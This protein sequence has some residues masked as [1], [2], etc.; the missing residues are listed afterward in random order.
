MN[1][2]RRIKLNKA[3]IPLPNDVGDEIYP[4][5]IFNFSISRILEHIAS[6]KLKAEEEQ[7]NVD[8]WF[9]SHIRGKINEE[10]LPNVNVRKP[11]IQAEI[12]PD[13]FELIDG[14]HRT[15]RASREGVE[16]IDSYKLKGEQL[17]PYFVDE[18]GYKAFIEYWNSKL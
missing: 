5:G 3:F 10:H 7:I 4:N 2:N 13:R 9:K 1:K 18:R 14:N 11:V 17:L 12:R 15:E 8:E 16:C 6:G